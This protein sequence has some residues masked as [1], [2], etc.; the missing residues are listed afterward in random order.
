M[1]YGE[2]KKKTSALKIQDFTPFIGASFYQVRNWRKARENGYSEP[3]PYNEY[4]LTAIPLI[5]INV[6]SGF[7]IVRGLESLLN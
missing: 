4:L 5:L 1:E 6:L 2:G 3:T 7:L